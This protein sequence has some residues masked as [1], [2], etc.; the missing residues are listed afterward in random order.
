MQTFDFT[1]N[2]V[3]VFIPDVDE[4]NDVNC[5]YINVEDL[6]SSISFVTFNILMINIRSCRKNFTNF[7]ACFYNVLT[8][9]SCVILTETWL[10][11]ESDSTFNIPGFYSYSL[12]RDGVGGGIKLYLKNSIQ[13]KLLSDLAFI[14]G[15]FEMLTVELLFDRNK[16]VLTSVYHP[17]TSSVARNNEFIDSFVLH[18]KMLLERKIPVIVAGDVNINLLNPYNY[19]YVDTFIYN[20]FELGFIPVVTLPT[21]FNIANAITRYSIID[22]IYVSTELR[23]FRSFVIPVDITDHFPVGA[24]LKLPFTFTLSSHVIKSRPLNEAGKATFSLLLSN[25]HLHILDDNFNITYNSYL[26]KVLESYDISFPIVTKTIKVRQPAPW[27]TPKLKQCVKKK[28]KLYKLYLKGRITKAEYSIYKN[29]LTA[30]LR[31][32]KKLYYSKLLY[33]ASRD[34]A[35]FWSCLNNILDRNTCNSLKEMKVGDMLL[36]GRDLANYINNYFVTAV[37]TITSNLTP[38]NIYVFLS[39]PV[40]ASCFFNPS[41]PVEV[42]GVVDALKNK[43]NGLLDLH[44]LVIKENKNLFS[45]HLSDLYNFSLEKSVFPAKSKI[46]RV[47]PVYKSGNTE[48][49]E[50]Y[51]PITVLPIF[52]KVFEKLTLTRMEGFIARFSILSSCQFGFRK[53]LGTA[54]AVIKLLS[55]ILPAYHDKI[56]SACFFLDLRKAFDTVDHKI[57][58]QKLSHYGFR[59]Q[60]HSYLGSYFQNR[61]QYVY[62]NGYESDIMTVSSVV[63]QGSILGPLCFSLFINDLPLAVDTHTVLFA[64]DAAFI[65]TSPSLEQLYNKIEKLFRDLECYLGNNRLV[66]NSSKSKLMMFSSKPTQDLRDLRFANGVVEWVNEFK[67][68]GLTLT[69]KLCFASHINRVALN[70]SRITGALT[71]IRSIVPP[72]V[73][74]KVYNALVFPHLTNHVVIWGSAPS[75]HL[76]VLVTRVNNLLRVILGVGWVDGRPSVCTDQMYRDNNLLRVESIFKYFLF[77]LLRQLLDGNLTEFFDTLLRP[78]LI[79]H[80]HET[81]SGVFRHPALRCEV[82]RRFLPYQ[83]ITLYDQLPNEL[84]NQR[85]RTS[86]RNFRL[87]LLNNQ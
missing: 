18:L 86:L 68:L 77:K 67:Y 28:S 34:A 25:I 46:G 41:T 31:R 47:T 56:Y 48:N 82:E 26:S 87:L 81:R 37:S 55:Y 49:I 12:Y 45:H 32:V 1:G 21:K 57:L 13:S 40:E 76:K 50:N 72:Y 2:D 66:P 22:H 33:D 61:E 9:F 62:V 44:P 42:A 19:V 6:L 30:L 23:N 7:L 4:W 24:L 10:T 17:P 51:R 39:D 85:H 71:N 75:C 29:R 20:M 64:D 3:P 54:H 35:K 79:S 38:P 16:V 53:G 11:V 14:N 73:L 65:I 36:A 15:L 80:T 59:G 43:G 70:I 83:L 8:Y 84:L 78:H 52:S 63:P 74:M 69:S 60:C 5:N 27:M 58:L